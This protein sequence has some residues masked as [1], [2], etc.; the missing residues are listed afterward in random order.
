[1]TTLFQIGQEVIHEGQRYFIHI[2]TVDCLAEGCVHLV[3]DSDDVNEPYA[4]LDD[5]A[6]END[7]ITTESREPFQFL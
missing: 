4:D 1:M 5:F 3:L 6:D 7:L 2:T